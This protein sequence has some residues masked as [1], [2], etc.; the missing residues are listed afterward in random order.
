MGKKA[1]ITGTIVLTIT[2]FITRILGFLFRIYMSKIMG[3]EGL[4]LY[5]LIF[6]IYMLIWAASSAG[7][8]LAVS[9]KV[10]E[11]TG[12]GNHTDAVRTLKSSLVVAGSISLLI[13]IFIFF[14]APWIAENYVREP[15]VVLGLKYLCVCVPFMTIACCIRGYFQGRQEMSISGIAQIIEQVARMLVIYLFAGFYLPK[16][17]MYACAL[18]TLGLCA[19]EFFSCLFTFIMFKIKQNKLPYSKPSQSYVSLMNTIITIAIPITANRFL[20]SGLVSLENILIPIQL[21]KYGLSS[22]EALAMYGM[23]S[24]MALPLLFFPSMV[25][26]SISTVLIPALSEASA[27]KNIR[28]LHKTVSKS[29]QYSSLIGIG[30]SCLFLTL[31]SEIAEICY[32]SEYYQVGELLKVLAVICPFLY[33]QGILTGMLNGLGLQ[34]L[35]FK[36][37]IIASVICI[38]FIFILVPSRGIMGFVFA[39]LIQSGFVT[40]YHL[41]N[42]LSHIS[43]RVDVMS[44]II[45]PGIAAISGCLIMKFIHSYWL[46]SIFSLTVSTILAVGILG[47]LYLSFLFIFKSLTKDDIMMFLR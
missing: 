22:S 2:G 6:P 47:V 38:A 37:N 32:G 5:Q 15:N 25:T 23:F 12:R 28:Y 31:G 41:L 35:T 3:A 20:T 43:L 1:L 46:T 14:S 17:I 42:V 9:K 18:G 7:I 44:W 4:G 27:K 11:F 21:Q 10:A 16:G 33:L 26:T 19:G 29:I 8:S 36:G 34:K 30:A 45:R 40:I 39:L 24:G 13:S